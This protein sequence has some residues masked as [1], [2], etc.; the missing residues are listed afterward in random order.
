MGD[1]KGAELILYKQA[2]L[3]PPKDSPYLQQ[4][5]PRPSKT[6][7]ALLHLLSSSHPPQE[8]ALRLNIF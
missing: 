4:R 3:L 1:R 6:S 2:I 5:Q 8:R 7:P